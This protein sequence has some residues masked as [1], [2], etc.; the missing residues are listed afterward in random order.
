MKYKVVMNSMGGTRRDYVTDLTWDEAY[1][2][3][4]D[5]N[6]Q[7]DAGYVWDLDIVEDD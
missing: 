4:C 5:H 1:D 6:W 3:C 7:Y 2:I